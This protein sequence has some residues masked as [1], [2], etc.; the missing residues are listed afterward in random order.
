MWV[1]TLR[2]FG[3]WFCYARW[4]SSEPNSRTFG[5]VKST[6]NQLLTTFVGSLFDWSWARGFTTGNSIPM[7]IESF[8]F[9]I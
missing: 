6:R 5:D 4:V 8:L 2:T 9:C 7:F 3:T 1:I